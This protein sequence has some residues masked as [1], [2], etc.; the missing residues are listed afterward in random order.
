MHGLYCVHLPLVD[1]TRER[2]ASRDTT[3]GVLQRPE[4]TA[5][6]SQK[7]Y[8][9]VYTRTHYGMGKGHDEM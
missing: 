7:V 3:I 6:I 1:G 9:F 2:H 4:N 5:H 8:V